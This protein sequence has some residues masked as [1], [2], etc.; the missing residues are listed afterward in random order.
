MDAFQSTSNDELVP[1]HCDAGDGRDDSCGVNTSFHSYAHSWKTKH[2]LHILS[3]DVPC[4]SGVCAFLAVACPRD[5]L[6]TVLDLPQTSLASYLD[7]RIFIA[8]YWLFIAVI[9]FN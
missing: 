3:V 8:G 2:L 1:F 4:F 7:E 9:P 5:I 6:W